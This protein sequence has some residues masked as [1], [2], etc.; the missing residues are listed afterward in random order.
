[1][2]R[3][4][5]TCARMFVLCATVK[6]T[7]V[8]VPVPVPV[9]DTGTAPVQHSTN[10]DRKSRKVTNAT[11]FPVF[12]DRA[13]DA[14]SRIARATFERIPRSST[15]SAVNTRALTQGSQYIMRNTFEMVTC[16]LDEGS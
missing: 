13:R 9:I 11:V 7:P 2:Y 16:Q 6:L 1:L 4:H 8:T 14:T 15:R 3:D 5:I 12:V 10:Y